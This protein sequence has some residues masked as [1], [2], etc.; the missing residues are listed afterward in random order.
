MA[1]TN[2]VANTL[3]W[4][5]AYCMGRS[6]TPFLNNEPGITCANLIL[7]TIISP[8][9]RWNWNR[10]SVKFLTSANVQDYVAA[11]STFGWIE[12]ASFIPAATITNVAGSGTVATMTANNAFNVGDLVTITG[13]TNTAF[14]VT[15]ATILTATSTQFTFAS[16][17]SLASTA[18]SGT[19]VAG[20]ASQITNVVNL[21]GAEQGTAGGTPN[22]ISP[23]VDDNAGNITF[24]ILPVPD[25]VYQVTVVF[26]KKIPALISATSSTWAPVPD[27]YA[28][29]YEWGYLAL[30]A[31]YSQDPR[32]TSFNQKFVTAILGACEGL[33]EEERNVFQTA[34][35]NSIT[36]QQVTSMRAQQGTQSRGV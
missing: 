21:L 12:N 14:N 35:L 5:Q 13:L 7:S 8:P 23:Q 18:D 1:S 10:N 36:E 33:D 11:V 15:N 9:F 22:S 20:K 29:I 19:A 34:W 26:Q 27:Q 6:L 28:Y 24:R 32:W 3:G 31:A 25:G 30:L 16:A 17:T 2:T 4:V